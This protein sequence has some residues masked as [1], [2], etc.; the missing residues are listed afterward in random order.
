MS[1]DAMYWVWLHSQSKGAGRHVMLAIANRITSDDGT[2]RVSTTELARFSNAARSSVIT[3]ID[4]LV[5][6]G[7]LNLL[8][9]GR[10]TR[11]ALYKIPGTV[12]YTR[13]DF[14]SRGP[15][16][17][18]LDGGRGSENRTSTKA[19][20]GPVTGPQGSENRTPSGPV[21]GPHNHNHINHVDEEA[22]SATPIREITAEDKLEFGRFWQLHPKSRDLDKTRDEW[23]AAVLSGVDPTKITAAAENYA[24][25]AA[26]QEWR[27]IKQSDRWIRERRYED[28]FAPRPEPGGK[29]KLRAV[30]GGWQPYED[31][32]D[33]S[34]YN[35][36]F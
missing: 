4:A 36:E 1:I 18:P 23:V 22:S 31:P 9:E 6:S 3:A 2:A 8:E 21:T 14:G 15:V 34:R 35:E 17:G 19:T 32:E 30:S 28:K 10:G 13:P 20:R 25:E 27:F 29:P 24:H 16:A 7:E 11:P 26:G 33:Q 12:G 5:K